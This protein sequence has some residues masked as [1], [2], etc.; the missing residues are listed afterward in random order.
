MEKEPSFRWNVGAGHGFAGT[1]GS[2]RKRIVGKEAQRGERILE[3]RG[4]DERGRER[5]PVDVEGREQRERKVQSKE[6]KVQQE[7]ER[8]MRS[9]QQLP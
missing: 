2:R 9:A 6:R 5:G 3:G 7:E 8:E 1:V 4:E